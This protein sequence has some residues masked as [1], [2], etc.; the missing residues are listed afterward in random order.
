[1]LHKGIKTKALNLPQ[2]FQS[3]FMLLG[4]TVLPD[5]LQ[6]EEYIKSLKSEDV[7]YDYINN[8]LPQV[9]HPAKISFFGQMKQGKKI[10]YNTSIQTLRK[11]GFFQKSVAI[12]IDYFAAVRRAYEDQNKQRDCADKNKELPKNIQQLLSICRDQDTSTF[13]WDKS[14]ADLFK[15]LQDELLI[16]GLDKGLYHQASDMNILL[17]YMFAKEMNHVFWQRASIQIAAWDILS[18]V[19]NKKHF[20]ELFSPENQAYSF[21]NNADF[22]PFE[23]GGKY[24]KRPDNLN[25]Q[26]KRN[27]KQICQLIPSLKTCAYIPAA[28]D[29][30]WQYLCDIESVQTE[31]KISDIPSLNNRIYTATYEIYVPPE[32]RPDRQ[33]E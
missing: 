28:R 16:L 1:M 5:F 10:L 4:L 19:E 2:E 23:N 11:N 8:H 27:L 26:K 33:R 20:N 25:N 18:Y 6:A 21:P 9:I 32:Y 3:S 15:I 24:E 22:T 7:L 14:D 13:W 30:A 31:Q 29:R 12:S 17:K